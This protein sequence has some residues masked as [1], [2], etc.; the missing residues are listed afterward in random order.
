MPDPTRTATPYPVMRDLS[1]E[2]GWSLAMVRAAVLQAALPQIAA[3]LAD[4]STFVTHPWRR[5][6][7]TMAS[8]QRQLNEDPAVRER[9]VDRL[10]RMH[11]RITGVG[12]DGAA[13]SGLD[14]EARAWV[15]A[16]LF[17]ST[18]AM[19]RTGGR[20]LDWGTQEQLY[21]EFRQMLA[22]FG[23]DPAL[24]PE[25]L[26]HFWPYYERM[27]SERLEHTDAVDAVLYRLLDTVPP[28]P[29]LRDQRA[30][31]T[32]IRSIAGPVAARITVA[33][34]PPTFRERVQITAPALSGVLMTGAY[35]GSGL[36]ARL[37]PTW[38]NPW[39]LAD[40]VDSGDEQP[41]AAVFGAL[42]RGASTLA[43]AVRMVR[44]N[45]AAA[46]PGH[47]TAAWSAERFFSHVL[48]QT[49]DGTVGWPDLAALAREIA[50]RLDLDADREAEVYGAFADWWQQLRTALDTDGD[51][52]ISAREYADGCA[53]VPVP[54]LVDLADVLFDVTD[55]DRSGTIS[56]EEY[57]RLLHT[58]FAHEP[59][60][61]PGADLTKAA[62][63]TEFLHF[64]AGRR[65][66]PG[67]DRLTTEG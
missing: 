20:P 67:W 65:P 33:S 43:S 34:L 26:A 51:G 29:L 52:A 63:T 45:R 61:P 28:P 50:S 64:M 19:R 48:D 8:V 55:T 1:R 18:V 58:A 14:P 24:L 41:V 6:H 13:Y 37:L 66:S 30:A 21:A 44:P 40:L 5:L 11:A 12:A 23:D 35:Q 17:E 59:A 46:R 47:E 42:L 38:S 2:L 32:A 31:W 15:I 7:N 4:Q 3:A 10:N 39:A 54:A 9:E 16:S 36:A 56:A 22:A 49:G 25:Q 57:R 27:L 53:T 62:F 60:D